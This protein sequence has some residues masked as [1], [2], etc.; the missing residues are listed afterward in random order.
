MDNNGTS[1]QE[2][3]QLLVEEK[4]LSKIVPGLV[5]IIG[6]I[7]CTVMIAMP[8]ENILPGAAWFVAPIGEEP[9]KM[10]GLI[11]LAL[12]VPAALRT[13]RDGLILGALAGL[14]FTFLENFEYVLG[15]ANVL[16]RTF[17]CSPGHIMWSAIVGMG[18]VLAAWKIA[19]AKSNNLSENVKKFLS[20]DV[21]T[22]LAI[23]MILHGLYDGVVGESLL[24]GIIVILASFYVVYKL[25]HYLPDR[26]ENLTM[27][28]PISFTIAALTAPKVKPAGT[29]A[30][31][32][33]QSA[34][35]YAA[36]PA[37][38]PV[39]SAPVYAAAPAPAPV[40]SAP[41]YTPAPAP[42]PAPV[43][44]P[45]RV[46]TTT[47]SASTA[48]PAPA[49]AP[50]PASVVAAPAPA[51]VPAP[52]HHFCTQCG[53]ENKIGAHFCAKCGNKL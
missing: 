20:I 47:A 25:Y 41:V 9:A 30:P 18:V 52:G 24:L 48:A 42:A 33:V 4:E 32:P 11:I 12:F 49:P 43:Q 22:F 27:T 15:G 14:G 2:L 17:I 21:L 3:A 7:I 51:P 46:R 6:G 19:E 10:I 29:M 16:L 13:K 53:T 5:A 28:N 34:P 40:Q 44:V 1:E 8:I 45:V 35:V 38:A 26:M 31:A 37:P 36:A 39:Q 23:A 50:V